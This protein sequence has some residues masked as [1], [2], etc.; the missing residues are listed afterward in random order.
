[1][2]FQIHQ[3]SSKE[4]R[5]SEVLPDLS[6]LFFA[7]GQAG[8]GLSYH[9]NNKFLGKAFLRKKLLTF[10]YRFGRF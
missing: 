1:M 4:I 5:L 8:I 2:L 6:K 7:L 9:L 10:H 3:V